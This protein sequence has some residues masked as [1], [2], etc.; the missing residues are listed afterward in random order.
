MNKEELQNVL[1][2]GLITIGEVAVYI[3]SVREKQPN[4]PLAKLLVR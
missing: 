1:K 3:N 4:L 2:L